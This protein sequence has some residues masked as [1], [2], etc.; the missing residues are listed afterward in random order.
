M[1]ERLY[2]KFK[3]YEVKAK[4]L[5]DFLETYTKPKAHRE[6]G[7]EYVEARIK[8]HAEDLEEYGYTFITHHD[9][10]SGEI[11]SYY[12]SKEKGDIIANTEKRKKYTKMKNNTI[13]FYA[14][15]KDLSVA[16]GFETEEDRDRYIRLSTFNNHTWVICSEQEAYRCQCYQNLYSNI[17]NRRK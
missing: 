9:S 15:H 4:S 8:S 6:R 13:A 7:N 1:S 11:V 17:L 3:Q 16:A 10:K 12:G 14:K 2:D 5:E